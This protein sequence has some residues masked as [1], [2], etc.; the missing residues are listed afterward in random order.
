MSSTPQDETCLDRTIPQIQMAF[1]IHSHHWTEFPRSPRRKPAFNRYNHS[2]GGHWPSTLLSF[3]TV[4][5]VDRIVTKAAW[6]RIANRGHRMLTFFPCWHC[7]ASLRIQDVQPSCSV[8]FHPRE[9]KFKKASRHLSNRC[10]MHAKSG[11]PVIT[12]LNVKE[13]QTTI[14]LGESEKH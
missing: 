14:I 13:L 5:C 12:L 7:T 2:L 9:L 11:S 10:S 1:A 6:I 3:I 8:V 4:L